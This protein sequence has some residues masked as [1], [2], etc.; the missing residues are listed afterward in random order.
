L[1]GGELLVIGLVTLTAG[2]V[3]QAKALLRFRPQP[4]Q[5]WLPRLAI[6]MATGLPIAIGG[7]LLL[8]D[9]SA[10]LYL[11]GRRNLAVVGRRRTEHL[12]AAG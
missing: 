2:F 7:A 5:W 1:L 12:G 8:G 10:G 11:D 3:L 6:I 9:F 4:V